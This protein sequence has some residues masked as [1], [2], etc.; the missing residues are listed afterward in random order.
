[1][2]PSA[3]GARRTRLRRH[4]ARRHAGDFC[5]LRRLVRAAALRAA[6]AGS[7]DPRRRPATH[8][9]S[10]ARAAAQLS[11]AHRDFT[12]RWRRRAR[13]AAAGPPRSRP[14]RASRAR[15]AASAA[16][17]SVRAARP[18]AARRN[19]RG[20]P[21]SR[22]T[23]TPRRGASRR[24]ARSQNRARPGARGRAG[25]EARAHLRQR[26]VDHRHIQVHHRE[27]EAGGG[28]D[29]GGCR[30]VVD[31]IG[32]ARKASA[33]GSAG[34]STD[35]EVCPGRRL[36]RAVSRAADAGPAPRCR[37]SARP[38]SAR[39]PLLPRSRCPRAVSAAACC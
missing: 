3:D 7:A 23:D 38:R 33:R 9:H 8:R 30:A 31:A 26:H 29:P 34:V 36:G 22:G 2:S 6:G 5:R 4:R 24:C 1:M 21:T 20:A 17:E 15:A 35:M 16:A 25:G 13:A 11:A 10:R 12:R 37:R 39:T 32:H 27:P 19:D 28:D 14:P 18:R